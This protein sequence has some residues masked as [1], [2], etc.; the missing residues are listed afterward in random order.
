M[1]RNFQPALSAFNQGEKHT[2]S[3]VSN[4]KETARLEFNLVFCIAYPIFLVAVAFSRLV[5]RSS[6]WHVS[7]QD[8]GKSIFKVAKIATYNS[9]PFAFM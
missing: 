7:D 2:M 9:I 1:T 5:P 6:R 8:D 3:S 4:G